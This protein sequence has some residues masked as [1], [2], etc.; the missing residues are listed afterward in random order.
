MQARSFF[1]MANR[2]CGGSL[3]YK[4]VTENVHSFRLCCIYTVIPAVHS[5]CDP[6]DMSEH[7]AHHL[8]FHSIKIGLQTLIPTAQSLAQFIYK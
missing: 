8:K 2:V 4:T 1:F 5:H 6:T 7:V 3:Y